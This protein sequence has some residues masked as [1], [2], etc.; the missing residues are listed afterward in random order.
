MV[1]WN[2][3]GDSRS[4][5]CSEFVSGK[6]YVPNLSLAFDMCRIIPKLL[7]GISECV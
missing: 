4:R 5:E 3:V 7:K 2:S 6:A 1:F